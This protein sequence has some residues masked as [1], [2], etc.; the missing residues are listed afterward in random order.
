MNTYRVLIAQKIIRSGSI[1]VLAES[2]KEAEQ[3]AETFLNAPGYPGNLDP[4]SPNASKIEW[5]ETDVDGDDAW[6]DDVEDTVDED[7]EPLY[8]GLPEPI[9]PE[10]NP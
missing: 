4:A 5:N 9:N 6:V 7:G 1:V 8:D 2:W 3:I 10:R